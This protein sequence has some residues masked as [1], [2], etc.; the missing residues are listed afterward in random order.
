MLDVSA[1]RLKT[2]IT[3]GSEKILQIP[4]QLQTS[5]SF[6]PLQISLSFSISLTL[7]LQTSLSSPSPLQD[8]SPLQV[9]VPLS[10]LANEGLVR[11]AG[12]Q[13]NGSFS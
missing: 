6:S 7:G 8:P 9:E 3:L 5:I 10:I 13:G 12:I 4:P 11:E 1:T 2:S